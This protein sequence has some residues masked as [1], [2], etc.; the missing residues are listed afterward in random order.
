MEKLRRRQFTMS[1][2]KNWFQFART[3][4]LMGISMKFQLF[5]GLHPMET[6]TPFKINRMIQ[7]I[8]IILANLTIFIRIV[9]EWE[10]IE[11][12]EKIYAFPAVFTVSNMRKFMAIC[13]G[14]MVILA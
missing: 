8:V 11:T 12:L 1:V 14:L 6:S 9:L 4:D 10:G 2:I 13:N 5:S 7:L 3:N